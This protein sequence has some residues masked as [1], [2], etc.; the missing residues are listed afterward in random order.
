MYCDQPPQFGPRCGNVLQMM[1]L[2]PSLVRSGGLVN[3]FSKL[4]SSVDLRT[5]PCRYFFI[6]GSAFGVVQVFIFSRSG[7]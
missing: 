3:I 5:I 2:P 1:E 4:Q 6:S 7:P